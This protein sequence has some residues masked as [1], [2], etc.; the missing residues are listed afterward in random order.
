MATIMTP[1]QSETRKQY[2]LEQNEKLQELRDL[3]AQG[4]EVGRAALEKLTPGLQE[5]ARAERKVESAGR[6]CL[7]QGKVSELTVI[8]PLGPGGAK[9]LRARL[10]LTSSV[11]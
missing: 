11:I 4:P 10:D 2:P 9:R 3:Y 5:Y 1:P 7:R 6:T 8:A